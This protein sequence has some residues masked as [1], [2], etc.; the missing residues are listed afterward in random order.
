MIYNPAE[1]MFLQKG[2]ANGAE[3]KNGFE[4][5]VTQAE[6]NWKLWNS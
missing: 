4:M 1:T 3:V 6:A 2:K 5:L